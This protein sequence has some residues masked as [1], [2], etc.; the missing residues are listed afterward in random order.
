MISF[1]KLK[2]REAL[3]SDNIFDLLQE[4]GGDPNRS[5]FGFTS[6]T[7]C[8]NPPGEGSRKLYYYENTG[9]F[10]CFTGCDEFFDIFQLVMKVSQ[11]Q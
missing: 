2:V 3:T 8:H 4:F 11:I 1:D 6:T 5:S 10:K 7:I 9:L